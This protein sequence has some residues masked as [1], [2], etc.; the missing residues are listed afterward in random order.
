MSEEM[1]PW[2]CPDCG[3]SRSFGEGV[4]TAGRGGNR[5]SMSVAT[6]L[7][8][9][10]RLRLEYIVAAADAI[11]LVVQTTSPESVCPTC[12]Q[13]ATRV[14]SRYHRTLAD[15][16]W[17][18][19]PVRLQL[20][21]RK[22]FCD[23]LDCSRRIFTERLPGIVHPSARRTERLTQALLLIG[24]ALGGEAGAR[25]VAALGM[26][27]S[28]DT[29]L[30]QIRQAPPS[31]AGA[32]KILGVDDWAFCR[33]QRYGTLLVDLERGCPV[34]LL[35]D[36]RAETLADWLKE[37]RGVQIVTRDRSWE[38]AQGITEGAP[39]AL[40]VVDRFHL[41]ANLREMLER[42]IERQRHHLLGIALPTRS[43]EGRGPSSQYEVIVRPRQPAERSPTEKATREAR[44]QHRLE[45]RRQA[46]ALR[47]EGESILGIARRLGLRRSTVYRYLR[48]QPESGAVRTRHVGSMLDAFLPYLCQR[49]S[50]GCHNGSQLWRELRE[51]GYRGSRKMV[52]V[53][54]QHQREAPAPTTPHQYRA[55]SEA[56]LHHDPRPASGAA[57]RPP[58]ARR[59]SWFLLRD[60]AS[61]CGA[62]QATL[63]AIHAAAP[64]LATIQPLVQ[65][66]QRLVRERDVAGFN[67]WREVALG[68]SLPELSSFI[69]GLDRD[70]EAV[71]AALTLP[72]SNGP[73][74]GQ[75]NRLKVIKRQ[76]YGRANFDL[77]RA[78]VLAA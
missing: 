5:G 7:P 36:R 3:V 59:I 58:S 42:V 35:P 14:H 54:T 60:P 45:L 40:Q 64:E 65:Q 22:F 49:W 72:W 74:E 28:P 37:H 51:R 19:V 75:V 48:G 43:P 50:E 56:S 18:G 66:F 26:R 57:R 34:D 77:L 6:L 53:W 63:T 70:R 39:D 62:E 11:T 16:P 1:R 52:A 33:G 23:R 21:C 46:Q 2:R 73:V 12:G 47:E 15:L 30:R 27:V 69:T 44:Y 25:L 29:L 10:H 9:P 20:S 78:R 8:D 24:Y 17:H 55:G 76:M 13:R 71:E 31:L 68:S 41:L 4:I 32:R 61:L 38:Y 67:A